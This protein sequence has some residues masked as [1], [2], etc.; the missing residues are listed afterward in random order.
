MDNRKKK[1][2][3]LAGPLDNQSAG[4]HVY[5]KEVIKHLHS[6]KELPFEVILIRSKK[7]SEYPKFKT[8]Y[9]P[10]Y[11]WIPGF[12]SIRLFILIPLLC[13]LHKANIVFEPAHFG[14]FNLPSWIKRVTVIHDL[15]PILFPQWHPFAGWFLHKLFI[16]T[17]LKRADLIIADSFSTENDIHSLIPQV[18]HKTSVVHLGI[19]KI[20]KPVFETKTLEKLKI[21]DNYILSVGTIEPRKNHQVVLDAFESI[22]KEKGHENLKWVIVGKRG[23]KIDNFLKN[24]ENSSA[25]RDIIFTNHISIEELVL[26][27]LVLKDL[28]L[29]DFSIEGL[30]L[31]N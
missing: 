14:P 30:V 24:V 17:I 5:T 26:K 19:S 6:I 12:A 16:T 2:V 15:T 27:D 11:N 3:I 1:L 28:V 8:I 18:S 25:Q 23:W 7:K 21:N 22:K 29:K 4:I 10:I 31:K 13:I 20:F 9:I